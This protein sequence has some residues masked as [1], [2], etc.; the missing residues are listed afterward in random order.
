[1]SMGEPHA[2]MRES[3]ESI[4]ASSLSLFVSLSIR[5]LPLCSSRIDVLFS[6]FGIYSIVIVLFCSMATFPGCFLL[7]VLNSQDF[8]V[9][10]V[11]WRF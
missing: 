4:S 1:M 6:S 5:F 10:P 2:H 3:I 9:F 7:G 8:P 11:L